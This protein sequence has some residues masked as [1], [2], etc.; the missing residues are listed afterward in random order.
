MLKHI[1]DRRKKRT[2]TGRVEAADRKRRE[3]GKE[4]G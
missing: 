2:G 3:K 1:S 4:A